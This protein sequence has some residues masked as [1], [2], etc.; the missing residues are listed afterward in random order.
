M[1][2]L[3]EV[4]FLVQVREDGSLIAEAYGDITWTRQA[5]RKKIQAGQPVP[6][7]LL[8]RCRL[9]CQAVDSGVAITMNWQAGKSRDAVDSLWNHITRNVTLT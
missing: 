2:A 6:S 1:L 4:H 3:Q 7:N 8:L 5:K 9:T